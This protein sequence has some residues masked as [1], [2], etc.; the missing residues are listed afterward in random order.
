M[1]QIRLKKFYNNVINVKERDWDQVQ[2]LWSG[3][4]LKYGKWVDADN[5]HCAIGFLI[6]T[7]LLNVYFILHYHSLFRKEFFFEWLYF[8]E[9]DIR[10]FLFF[11][12][13]INRPSIKCVRNWG[14]GGR[15]SK[16]CTSAYRGM[17]GVTPYVSISFSVFVLWCLVLFVEI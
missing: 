10:M 13:L 16:M 11:F 2:R 1:I 17:R 7:A 6:N 15:S 14:N 4:T 3:I 8:S 12:W 9:Y 5:W